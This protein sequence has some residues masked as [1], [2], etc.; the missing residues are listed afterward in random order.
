ME[1]DKKLLDIEARLE[2]MHNALQRQ[3]TELQSWRDRSVRIPNW[4]RNGGIALMMAVFAQSMAAV[5]WASKVE[6]TQNNIMNDVKVNTEF[7]IQSSERYNEIMIE[8]TKLQIMMET[9]FNKQDD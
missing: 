1:T 5:W 6:N 7:R 3:E 4:I 2:R 8:L 9:H